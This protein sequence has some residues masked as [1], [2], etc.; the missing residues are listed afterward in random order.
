MTSSITYPEWGAGIPAGGS[1]LYHLADPFICPPEQEAR[2]ESLGSLMTCEELFLSHQ[3]QIQ[4]VVAWVCARHGL[5]GADAEDFASEVNLRL[6][7]RDCEVLTKF[8]GRSSIGTY[9]TTVVG[10]IYQDFQNKRF[11]KWRSSAEARRLG[12]VAVKLE[13]LVSRDGL[14]FDEAVGVLQTDERVGMTREELYDLF[15]RLPR[16]PVRRKPG[17]VPYEPSTLSDGPLTLEQAE[18]QK[19]ARRVFD[20]VRAELARLPARD[21]VF[22]RLH[23]E[24]GLTVA[25]AARHLG[26]DQKALYRKKEAFLKTVRAALKDKGL[27]PTDLDDL[28]TSGDWNEDLSPDDGESDPSGKDGEP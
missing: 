22:L 20:V 7:E 15:Q 12:P 3:A 11:G 27:G 13:R 4:R 17:A 9:L 1:L 6:I 24:K 14:T 16:R 28:L 10:H 5:R 19:L 2:V 23:F 8:E 18:R 21:Q 26:E 25:Q